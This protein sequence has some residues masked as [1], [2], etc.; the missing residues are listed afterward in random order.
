MRVA[1]FVA[2]FLFAIQ[3]V[4]PHAD[5]CSYI[6]CD[7][8]LFPRAGF[9]VPANATSFVYY[10]GPRAQEQALTLERV[11]STRTIVAALTSDASHRT[12][13]ALPSPLSEGD[14]FAFNASE[15]C[16][17]DGEQLI[18]VGASAPL[19]TTLGA[20]NAM[21]AARAHVSVPTAGGY[22]ADIVQGVTVDVEA[23]LSEDAR[24]WE[25]MLI[26][27]V[28]VDG[29]VFVGQA[30][31]PFDQPPAG[32][33]HHGFGTVELATI[34]APLNAGEDGTINYDPTAALSEG[35]HEVVFRAT[36][37]GTDTVVTTAPITVALHCLDFYS[38]TEIDAA[39]REGGFGGP[40]T[41]DTEGG[42]CSVTVVGSYATSFGA[43]GLLALLTVAVLAR[44]RARAR[45]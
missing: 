5:A 20:L 28:L 35:D 21:S 2:S 24:P 12:V 36:V 17:H 40:T 42:A 37:A 19:P 9:T 33:T 18:H 39:I 14:V 22:C 26:Y 11:A 6:D 41:P 10:N 13:F 3:L 25:G 44:A 38:Q 23:A 30:Y 27:E 45:A 43:F 8:V 29:A 4:T 15:D 32:A 34:C 31:H 1:V 16:R 7:S